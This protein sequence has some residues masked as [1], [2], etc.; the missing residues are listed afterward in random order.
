MSDLLILYCD[1]SC[2]NRGVGKGPGGYGIAYV[3][4]KCIMPE[5]RIYPLVSVGTFEETT[6]NRMEILAL[7]ESIEFFIKNRVKFNKVKLVVRTDSQYVVNGFTFWIE[8][9]ARNNFMTKEG[10]PIKNRELWEKVY[11]LKEE[12]RDI[13][14][15]KKLSAVLVQWVK[16]HCGD[17]GNESADYL[18]RNGAT[19]A[20]KEKREYRLEYP[21]SSN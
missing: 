21:F 3:D 9:W 2:L 16:G 15:T 19:I 7:I 11:K 17:L 6:N 10:A 1:G 12:L 8:G 14:K 20:A 5:A 18:A 4:D 13:Y